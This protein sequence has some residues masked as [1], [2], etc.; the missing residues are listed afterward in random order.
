MDR[1]LAID[2]A[3]QL[4]R[5]SSTVGR[6]RVRPPSSPILFWRGG[7]KKKKEAEEAEKEGKEQAAGFPMY[8]PVAFR[9]LLTDLSNFP[10]AYSRTARLL[11]ARTTRK[12]WEK[13]CFYPFSVERGMGLGTSLLARSYVVICMP[14]FSLMYAKHTFGFAWKKSRHHTLSHNGRH[15][16]HVLSC[17]KTVRTID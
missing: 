5:M 1:D 14:I 17:K 8:Y 10:N 11:Y 2:N 9:L 3:C 13:A 12:L 4:R 7:A 6:I 16:S 15:P